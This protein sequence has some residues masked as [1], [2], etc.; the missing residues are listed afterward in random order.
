MSNLNIRILNI[1]ATI[2]ISFLF[3]ACSQKI[4]AASPG[5]L[6]LPIHAA[7]G[8]GGLWLTHSAYFVNPPVAG[9]IMGKPSMGAM[10]V[11]LG[12][13]KYIDLFSMTQTIGNRVELGYSCIR[14][15]LG[16]LP[17]KIEQATGIDIRDHNAILHN[18][19]GRF[20]I[21]QEG[22]FGLSWIPAMTIGVHYKY[23]SEINNI[24]DDLGGALETIHLKDNDGWDF[25]IYTSKT[26]TCL[27]KIVFISLG[28]RSTKG[29][30]IGLIGFTDKRRI[31]A[32]GHVGIFLS[33]N[34]IAAVEYR[35]KP[36]QFD[37]APGLFKGEDDWWALSVGYIINNNMTIGGG[38][39]HFGD[40]LNHKANSSW[41]VAVKWE[42]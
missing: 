7:E 21:L 9:K 32:E 20:A 24:N 13:E 27:P 28:A 38:W 11:N 14:A 15:H 10:Y 26:I 17:Q 39:G 33:K 30:Q 16:D 5:S 6:P 25:T 34:F 37:D 36:D 18:F 41:G 8:V 4:F 23:N 42:F 29:A 12:H 22:H 31:V 1:P 19:N 3:F 40:L 2:I 35:E